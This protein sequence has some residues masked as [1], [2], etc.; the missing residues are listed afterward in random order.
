M[1]ILFVKKIITSPYLYIFIG[2]LFLSYQ[3]Y[4]LGYSDCKAEWDK[5]ILAIKEA[6]EILL[7]QKNQEIKSLNDSL[8]ELSKEASKINKETET[9]SETITKRVYV[10]A[11]KNPDID[12][13]I[14]VEWLRTY[15]DS[16]P[17]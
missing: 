13:S 15:A 4:N 8:Y 17:K 7:T 3:V 10:Y 6:N 2:V 16:L 12:K 5:S 1:G 11:E 14:D 9:K